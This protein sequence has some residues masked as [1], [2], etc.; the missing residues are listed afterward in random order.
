[1]EPG[2][3]QKAF[4]AFDEYNSRDPHTEDWKGKTYPKELLYHHRMTERLSSYFPDA[5][6]YLRLAARCQ[7]IGRWEI[8]RNAYPIDRKGYLQWRTAEKIHHTKIAEPI[9]KECGYDEDTIEKVKSLLMKKE[10]TTNPDTQVLEDVV[11]LVFMEFYLDDFAAQHTDEKVVD[12]LRKTL[13]KMS[14]RCIEES[15]YLKVS[16]RIQGLLLQAVGG[17]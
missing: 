4:N 2:K 5:P 16:E 13:K 15:Q 6:E 9:L 8:A 10:L 17:N 12:I 1:M 14:P 11:C 3:L 7:H